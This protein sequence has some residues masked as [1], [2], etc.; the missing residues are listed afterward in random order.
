[1][2]ERVDW[3]S[4]TSACLILLRKRVGNLRYHLRNIEIFIGIEKPSYNLR[5]FL[6][7]KPSK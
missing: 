2:Y 7:L 4:I 3:G 6:S 1:M 5:A